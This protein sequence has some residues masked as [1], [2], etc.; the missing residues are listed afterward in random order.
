MKRGA[1]AKMKFCESQTKA[2]WN[3]TVVSHD[4]TERRQKPNVSVRFKANCRSAGEVRVC[5]YGRV[6]KN[7]KNNTLKKQYCCQANRTI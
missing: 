5:W 6:L 4:L 7:D 2:S 1:K 3:L